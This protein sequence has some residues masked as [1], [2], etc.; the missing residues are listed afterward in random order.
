M[1][2]AVEQFAIMLGRS[3]RRASRHLRY[4]KPEDRDDVLAEAMLRCW[5]TRDTFDPTKRSLDDWFE[6]VLRDARQALRR[7]ERTTSL[8]RLHAL[9]AHEDTM[10]RMELQ[11]ELEKFNAELTEIER[12]IAGDIAAGLSLREIRAR[13]AGSTAITRRV[14]RK[15]SALRGRLDD[16]S[17]VASRATGISREADAPREAA[18]IDHEIEKMLRRPATERADCPVCWRC[19]WFEGLK[20]KNWQPPDHIHE[21][22][23][24]IAVTST[25]R[26]KITIAGGSTD[27]G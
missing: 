27:V 26:E 24:R 3:S 10:H 6:E 8:D 11:Q 18:P 15:L 5:E 25:E 16:H 4:L 9:A 20:P 12:H 7:R 14:Y 13:Y 17:G 1:I 21:V 2:T 23:V 22:E 19:M